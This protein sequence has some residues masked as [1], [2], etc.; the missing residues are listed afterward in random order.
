MEMYERLL[1]DYPN[2]ARPY[3][4][5]GH[6][7]KTVGR[8]DDAIK[9]YRRSIELSPGIGE[10]YWSLANLKTFRFSDED[11]ANMREQVLDEGGDPDDPVSPG[12]CAG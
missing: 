6:T 5:Y 8:L 11:I 3:T 12:V 4:N 9:A 1:K 7:L 10:S 2:Q